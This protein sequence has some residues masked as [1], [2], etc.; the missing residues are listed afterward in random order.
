[1][2]IYLVVILFEIKRKS[3]GADIY[4]TEY[5]VC[6]ALGVL[7]FLS[8]QVSM[9]TILLISCFRL[10]SVVC[11]FKKVRLRIV[12]LSYRINMDI[13]DISCCLTSY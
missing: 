4:Y 11:P 13:M 12:F 3:F 2:E 9:S 8:S 7:N 6:N 1:M 5:R 10:Y